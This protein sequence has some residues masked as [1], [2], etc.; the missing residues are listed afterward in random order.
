MTEVERIINEGFLPES[1]FDEEIR[2]DFV[3]TK[4]RKKIWAIEM[5]LFRKLL[6]ICEKHNLKI[7]G[8]G[9]TLLGAVRHNGFIP[10]D[11]D[12]D[13][14]MPRKDYEKLMQLGNKEFEKPYFLQTP[15]TDPGY[16]YSYMK[17]RNSNTTGISRSFMNTG[18]NQ[19]IFIDIFPLDNISLES[20]ESD[21]AKITELIMKNSSYMKKNSLSLLDERQLENYYK[22][23][24]DNPL[25]EF[26]KMQ[27]IA[28]NPLYKDSEYVANCMFVAIKS[29]AQIWKKNWFEKTVFHK[30]EN[31]QMPMPYDIEARL[32]T[33]YGDYMQFPPLEHRGD[34]HSDIIW[35]PDKKYTDYLK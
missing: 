5:D 10:W 12:I 22:Y 15:Y 33:Q 26:E 25:G 11:D 13:V 6:S 19:G 21:K 27:E 35:D 1:F 9:G 2:C 16:Y 23:Q 3:V 24:T 8:D 7:W 29:S 18:F 30:F 34:R 17:F 4:E 28:T 32:T 20:F 31:I 14:I